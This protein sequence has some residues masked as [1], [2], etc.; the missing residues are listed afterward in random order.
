VVE[1]GRFHPGKVF[2][3]PED[4]M[5]H[6]R[7]HPG[8]RGFTLIELLVVIAIIAILAGLLLPALSHAKA[9]AQR[10][11]C[12]NNQKQLALTWVMYSGDNSDR[13]APNGTQFPSDTTA[14]LW[15]KG[16]YHNFAASFTNHVYLV[17]RNHALFAP[18]LATRSTYQCPSDKT[19]IVVTRGRPIPQ[20]RSYAMNNY[21]G[22]DNSI[23]DRLSGQYQVFRRTTDLVNPSG[24]FLTQDLTPQSLCT[25]AFIV[26]M[27]GVGTG[28]SFFHLPATHHNRGGVVSFTD[29]HVEGHRWLDPKIFQNTTTGTR[30][31][32]NLNSPKSGDLLWIRERTTVQR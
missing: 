3:V 30:L 18:Y 24:L 15:V 29:G 32:H 14:R 12:L 26:F 22:T 2:P 1:S 9:T 11:K 25:P 4:P 27:P 5:T 8:F 21:V 23:N 10:A 31:A 19:T 6:T 16:G 20:V 13:L 28:D 17:D 7:H